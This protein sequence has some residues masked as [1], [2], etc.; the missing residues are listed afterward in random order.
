MSIVGCLEVST[1]MFPH[2]VTVYHK[3]Q[4]TEKYTKTVI[5]GVYWYGPHSASQNGKGRD[6]GESVT[7]VV[8][9]ATMGKAGI[10]IRTEDLIL[11]GE[12]PDITSQT[13]LE[14]T[15]DVATVSSVDT[16]DVGSSLD[17]VVI[18]GV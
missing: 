17:C 12:G 5:E 15:P 6:S 4:E 3:D 7:V 14:G 11:K 16:N 2:T 1:S 9:L 13:D 8:P 10:T 18:S